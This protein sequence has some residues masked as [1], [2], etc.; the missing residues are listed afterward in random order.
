MLGYWAMKFLS[1]VMIAAG[2][3]GLV[4]EA[5]RTLLVDREKMLA[6]ADAHNITVV[7]KQAKKC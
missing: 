2:S 6:L 1:W 5:G 4:V 7:A 3:V